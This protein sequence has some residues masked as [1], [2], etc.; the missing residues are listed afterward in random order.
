MNIQS[1]PPE[2]RARDAQGRIVERQLRRLQ[3]SQFHY[4]GEVANNWRRLFVFLGLWF[5]T[6]VLRFGMQAMA[7]VFLR[8]VPQVHLL[9]RLRIAFFSLLDEKAE[10]GVPTGRVA[11]KSAECETPNVALSGARRQAGFEPE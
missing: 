10:P 11:A 6:A 5:R 1:E 4:L 3:A 2:S 9:R 7:L 8:M